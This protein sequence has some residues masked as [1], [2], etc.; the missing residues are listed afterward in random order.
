MQ[1][2]LLALVELVVDNGIVIIS[3][4]WGLLDSVPDAWPS[5]VIWMVASSEGGN[6]WDLDRFTVKVKSWA[7]K[8]R[9]VAI[10][11]SGSFSE[12]VTTCVS[13]GPELSGGAGASS[14]KGTFDH[15]VDS[16]VASEL[17]SPGLA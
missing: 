17:A 10:S 8:G 5:P 12:I 3:C 2:L 16:N 13:R 9:I 6:A 15:I 14:D 7:G 4:P 11:W 1:S